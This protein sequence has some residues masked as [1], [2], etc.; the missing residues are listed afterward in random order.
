MNGPDVEHA[1]RN[2]L[3][4]ILGYT[5]LLLQDTAENDPRRE[6]IQEILKATRAALALV[7]G[8]DAD[9]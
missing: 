1:L 4:I 8:Q 7:T 9:R 2:H 5:E 6:D 3:A